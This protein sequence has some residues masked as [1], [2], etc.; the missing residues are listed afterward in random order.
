MAAW[1]RPGIIDQFRKKLIEG[2]LARGLSQEFAERV[3]TQIRGFGEY[4]FP[5]IDNEKFGPEVKLVHFIYD[6]NMIEDRPQ[7]IQDLWNTM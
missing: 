1:R 6:N 3:F 2:M 7:W 4:G 5:L